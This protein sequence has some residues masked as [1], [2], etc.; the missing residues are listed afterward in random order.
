V[1]GR[2]SLNR[3]N[4]GG[5]VDTETELFDSDSGRFK[6]NPNR[7]MNGENEDWVFEETERYAREDL[8][9]VWDMGERA[10]G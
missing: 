8:Y 3:N 1:D 7:E 4:N 10:T 2:D 9:R 5:P 6:G